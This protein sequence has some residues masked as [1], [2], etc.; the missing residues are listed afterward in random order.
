MP[1]VQKY[2]VAGDFANVGSFL[3][4]KAVTGC[5]G[6]AEREIRKAPGRL[7]VETLNDQQDSRLLKLQ[8]IGDIGIDTTPRYKGGGVYSARDLMNL[9]LIHI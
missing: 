7:L 2:L 5:D 4:T 8:K 1:A 6:S 9:S 3:I